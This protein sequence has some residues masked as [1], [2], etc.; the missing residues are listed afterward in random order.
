MEQKKI[1]EFVEKAQR[2]KSPEEVEA[3]AK[4]CG[5]ELTAEKVAKLEKAFRGAKGE[6]TDEELDGVSGGVDD[7]D[8]DW[9]AEQLT[10]QFK[11]QLKDLDPAVLDMLKSFLL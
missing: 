4:A 10:E 3:A 11:E 6:L 5:L 9:I 2:A 8:I 7:D 1:E